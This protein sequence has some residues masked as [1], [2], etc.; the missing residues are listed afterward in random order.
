MAESNHRQD[1]LNSAMSSH[2]SGNL[3]VA[4][5][6]YKRYLEAAPNHLEICSLAAEAAFGLKDFEQA[7]ELLGRIAKA[8]PTNPQAHFNLGVSLKESGQL[9]MAEKAFHRA[10]GLK[11]SYSAAQFQLALLLTA[12]GDRGSAV[13]AFRQVI[14]SDP[15]NVEALSNCAVLL[16]E[17]GRLNE[18]LS[19]HRLAVGK[20]PDHPG[21][22]YNY[23]LALEL[24]EQFE[25]AAAAFQKAIDNDPKFVLALSSLGRVMGHL[26]RH[27]DSV[28]CYRKGLGLSPSSGNLKSQL[29]VALHAAGSFEDAI[30]AHRD[31]IALDP[32][33]VD[34]LCAYGYTL[35]AAQHHE[36]AIKIF[37]R[38]LHLKP[39]HHEAYSRKALA[40]EA[41][42][43]G[44]E[45]ITDL[46][47]AVAKHP[48]IV[49][50]RLSLARTQLHTGDAAG[51]LETCDDCLAKQPASTAALAFRS[52][53]LRE[54]GRVEEAN[55]LTDLDALILPVKTSHPAGFQTMEAFNAAL[56]SHILK[57]PTLLK[58]PPGHATKGGL[59][60]GELLIEPKGPFDDFEKT[61]NAAVVRYKQQLRHSADHPFVAHQPKRWTLNVW[62]VVL[63]AGGHQVPHI[64]RGAWLSG[65]YYAKVPEVVRRSGNSRAGWIE[66][67]QP[68]EK[69]NPTA[70]P[71]LRE[72]CPE[73]GLMVLFPA[74]FY[75]R[76]VPFD[77]DGTRISIAFD[78]VPFG[79][80]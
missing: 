56:I 3:K 43:R 35:T 41:L 38:A 4:L 69:L 42:G 36:D 46:R 24:T 80:S 73:E 32:A 78:I 70:P 19:F 11:P 48:D 14:D 34:Y 50:L 5:E 10:L 16:K 23:G 31:A 33:S 12:Q 71:E 26:G 22:N 75:H 55:A 30:D 47:S 6:G 58:D 64:H 51:A 13:E 25:R 59:H 54:L 57:H 61:I 8:Q 45:I 7:A 39:D 74:Y 63:E 37:D 21:L 65:V 68:P 15:E 18:S 1:Q 2:R 67:G 72:I 17:M 20:R 76:T 77:A 49:N 44:K 66:F 53:A 79:E 60:T 40:L 28:E 27:K 9:K 62:S 52:Q 29:G